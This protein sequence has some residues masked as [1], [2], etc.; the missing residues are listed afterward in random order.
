MTGLPLTIKY[1]HTIRQW[2]ASLEQAEF[3]KDKGD[4]FLISAAGYGN[5]PNEA[6]ND[7]ADKLN[8]RNY[9]ILVKNAGRDNRQEFD[10]SDITIE[11]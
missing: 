6:M 4:S 7:F 3:K 2:C 10:I 1:T 11:L 8:N 9:S 5:T